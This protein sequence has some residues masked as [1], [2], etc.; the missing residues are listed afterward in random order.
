MN[1]GDDLAELFD[2]VIPGFRVHLRRDP[3]LRTRLT[4]CQH[5]INVVQELEPAMTDTNKMFELFGLWNCAGYDRQT[6]RK[7]LA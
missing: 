1:S 6:R 7:V 3:H 4:A 5:R 2:F